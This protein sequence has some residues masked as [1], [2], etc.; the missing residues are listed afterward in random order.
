[1]I[2]NNII[3]NC[4]VTVGDVARAEIFYGKDIHALKVNT[5]RSKPEEVVTDYMEIPK[6]ILEKNKNN[7]LSIYIM[8]VNKIPFLTTISQHVKF[9]TVN[10]PT[11]P[12][13]R[14][15]APLV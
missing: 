12:V 2:S 15:R 7:T 6:S 8:Y 3:L 4:P 1:M 10:I 5:T 9:T 11:I 14:T 13:A